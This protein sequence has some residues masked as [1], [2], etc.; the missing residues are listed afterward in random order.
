M[1]Y[2]RAS[3]PQTVLTSHE[4]L[5]LI[6][7][8]LPGQALEEEQAFSL[9][10]LVVPQA[11]E[12]SQSSNASHEVP[13]FTSNHPPKLTLTE[14]EPPSH[15]ATQLPEPALVDEQ[16][17]SLEFHK[18]PQTTESS[19]LLD[20]D[21]EPPSLASIRLQELV[22][23]EELAIIR[24]PATGY[25]PPSRVSLIFNLPTEQALVEELDFHVR[26]TSP[27]IP[28]LPAQD[29][30][31]FKARE[32]LEPA[33]GDECMKN[34]E[35]MSARS[36]RNIKK[37]GK[38][39]R[40]DPRKNKQ[41][42][43]SHPL[44]GVENKIEER[45]GLAVRY[46]WS[47]PRHSKTSG[48]LL[49]L[50]LCIM[51]VAQ[52]LTDCQIMIDWLPKMF[53]GAG[54]SCCDQ[55]GITCVSGRITLMY[56]ILINYFRQLYEQEL[57]G[58]IPSYLGDLSNLETL[59]L[60]SNRLSGE[61]P[62]SLGDLY[63]LENLDLSRNNLSGEIPAT[64]G[65]L[66]A[67]LTLKLGNN[68][69]SGDIPESIGS[70]SSLKFLYLSNNLLSGEIPQSLGSLSSLSILD[71][72]SNL[73]SGEIPQ[74][75]GSLS[76]LSGL[77][78]GNNQLNGAIPHS[79]DGLSSLKRINLHDNDLSGEIPSTLGS[80]A[81][82]EYLFLNNNQ[83]NGSIPTSL[84]SHISQIR[85]QNN[86]LSGSIPSSL[87]S[88][89]NLQEINL[90]NNSLAGPVPELPASIKR[91]ELSSNADLCAHPEIN[92]ICTVGLTKCIMDCRMMNAWLPKMFDDSKCCSQSG[93][94]CNNDRITNLYVYF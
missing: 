60:S 28:P 44:H 41:D 37:K 12:S 55:T 65:N 31:S 39:Y 81:S 83:L 2:Q 17:F 19:G 54:T 48:I 3:R 59:V 69:F 86:L 56:V 14:N 42:A 91:C 76:F 79:F 90:N 71:L 26:C 58:Q 10:S 24:S 32:H 78:L 13:W 16:E 73:L 77:Y 4:P 62:S 61:V 27:L 1:P 22:L 70:M 94:E 5:S 51:G 23:Q 57:T 30:L 15:T 75:L 46:S 45:R 8:Q 6:S 64:L 85:L 21:Y 87:G 35:S 74:S 9:E 47:A 18:V 63:S 92:H 25:E 52:A 93:I 43:A 36:L 88:V 29:T 82:L 89:S 68:Q 66:T 53:D 40:T 34:T 49:L 84:G 20:T 7:V 72:S 33:M 38:I 11:T 50:G 80:L 67:L